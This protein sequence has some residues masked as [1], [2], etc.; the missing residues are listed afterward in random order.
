MILNFDSSVR[1]RYVVL[2]LAPQT[3]K[4]TFEYLFPNDVTQI[5]A[6]ISYRRISAVISKS[7]GKHARTCQRRVNKHIM[8]EYRNSVRQKACS[9]RFALDCTHFSSAAF[10][11]DSSTAISFDKKCA[12]RSA[13]RLLKRHNVVS[14]HLDC[15]IASTSRSREET[16]DPTLGKRVARS[17]IE[18]A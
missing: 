13:R 10:G 4:R 1:S 7:N 2:Q 18:N 17:G 8:R 15:E 5:V 3:R 14:P 16:R 12:D 6:R 9:G 11:Y